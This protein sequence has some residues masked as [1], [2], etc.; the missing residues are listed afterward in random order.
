MQL[1][2]VG[3]VLQS[4]QIQMFARPTSGWRLAGWRREL[5]ALPWSSLPPPHHSPA[6]YSGLAAP[7]AP[8]VR[9]NSYS[10]TALAHRPR[11]RAPNLAHRPR[12][13][14]TPRVATK[15]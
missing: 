8:Q 6:I 14:G 9:L 5:C 10:C 7:Q 15:T 12:T 13:G 4:T 1:E 11:A 3:K 2:A